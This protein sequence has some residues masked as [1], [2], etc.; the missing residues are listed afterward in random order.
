MR[1]LRLLFSFILLT[2]NL[3]AQEGGYSDRMSVFQG[4]EISFFISTKVNPFTLTISR[5]EDTMITIQTVSNL[6]GVEYPVPDSGYAKGCGW[7]VAYLFKVPSDLKPGAYNAGFKTSINYYNIVFFVKAKNPGAYSKVLYIASTNTWQ[8]YNAYGGKSIYDY[9][10]TGGIRSSKVTMLRPSIRTAG[11][12]EFVRSE[13]LLIRWLFNNGINA[14]YAVE[15][16]LHANPNY[17]DNYDVVFLV[18]HSEYWSYEQRAQIE[19]FLNRGG[20]LIALSGN[21]CWWQVRFEDNGNTMVCYKDFTDPLKGIAD[22]LVTTNWCFPPL[23]RVESKFLGSSFLFGGYVNN[24]GVLPASE[25]Y[26]GYSVYNSWHW[27]FSN[28]G[29]NEGEIFGQEEGI[30]GNEVD[31]TIVKWQD[32]IPMPDSSVSPKNYRILGYSPA[33]SENMMYAS[34][35]GAMGIYYNKS[36]G[37]VF[38]AASIL[39]T[40]GINTD[41]LVSSIV[42]NVYKKFL[43]GKIPPEINTWSPFLVTDTVIN[44]SNV[45]LNKREYLYKSA[46][47]ISFSVLA[48]DVLNRNLNYQW[49][50]NNEPLGNQAIFNYNY[51]PATSSKLVDVTASIY[52]S[53]DSSSIS[54]KLFNTELAFS[55]MPPKLSGKNT[56]YK[57][58]IQVFNAWK[59]PLQ[60]V[61]NGPSW[62]TYK[63]G[64]LSGTVPDS[65]SN[66]NIKLQVKNS[67]NQTDELNYVLG[68][69]GNENNGQDI[70]QNFILYQNYPNPFNP[71][72][73]IKYSFNVSGNVSLKVYDVIGREIAV[74]V[75]QFQEK[76]TYNISFNGNG[77]ASGIYFY[78]LITPAGQETKK[79]I[80]LR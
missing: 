7:P 66:Y 6:K 71:A 12:P 5:Y 52:N 59:D 18:G 74:L 29:L 67:H 17:L 79:L 38:D 57:W 56:F 8:A 14:D 68:I 55:E 43:S 75:N 32:G 39:F 53:E 54:W 30:V 51:N 11:F 28:T 2:I 37:A 78:R 49:F 41:Y 27:V 80:I 58:R 20:K 23:N 34:P 63:D 24:N 31:G 21:N 76:G 10:S 47:N 50:V 48:S 1:T 61:Y 26:G 3:T 73:N 45:Q 25:G 64:F 22:S 33:K 46:Q 4:D 77:L 60:I 44:N 36:G 42:K 13:R 72:T 9:N 62:L 69:T 16:D 70:P 65:D 35:I 40:G 15:Y 19:K